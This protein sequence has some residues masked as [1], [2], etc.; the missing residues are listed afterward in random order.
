MAVRREG[1]TLPSRSLS[2]KP[3][4]PDTTPDMMLLIIWIHTKSYWGLL[5]AETHPPPRFGGSLFSSLCVI[6]LIN[7]PTIKLTAAKT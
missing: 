4:S 6:L 3:A 5:W 2:P 7:Q 1:C